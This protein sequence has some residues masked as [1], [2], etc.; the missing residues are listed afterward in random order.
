MHVTVHGKPATAFLSIQKSNLQFL[1][2]SLAQRCHQ[3][4][5]PPLVVP[6]PARP[7]LCLQKRSSFHAGKGQQKH[8]WKRLSSLDPITPSLMTLQ[9]SS[10]RATTHSSLPVRPTRSRTSPSPTRLQR[11]RKRKSCWTSTIKPLKI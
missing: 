3:N 9:E 8:L 2:T 11:T 5:R 7:C 10:L 6:Q 4:S 1:R